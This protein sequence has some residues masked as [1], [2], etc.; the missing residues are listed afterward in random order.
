MT[1]NFEKINI[2]K[3]LD[4][5]IAFLLILGTHSIFSVAVNIDFH[6]LFL[7]MFTIFNRLLLSA[8]Y[9][10]KIKISMV[11]L[12]SFWAIYIFS[13]GFISGGEIKNLFI[14]FILLFILLVIYFFLM[15]DTGQL[16]VFFRAFSNIMLIIAVISIIFWILGSLF[17]IISPNG[18][19][20]F[21]W[22]KDRVAK[23]YNYIYVE[24][25]NDAQIFGKIIYRNIGIFTEAPMF[26]LNLSIALLLDYFILKRRGLRRILLYGLTF[27][28]TISIT[29][30]LLFGMALTLGPILK[31]FSSMLINK[32][33]KPYMLAIP[34]IM[35]AVGIIGV[36]LFNN[37][38][39]SASGSSR[40]EDY[41][42]GFKAWLQNPIFGSGFAN[43]DIRKQFMS[44]I[45]LARAEDGFTNSP[46]T[47]LTEGGIFF[48]SSYLFAFTYPIFVSVRTKN[49][50]L[51]IFILMW[52]FLFVTTTFEHTSA[53]IAFIAF[54]F[55][56]F[57]F[58]SEESVL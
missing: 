33:I 16:K 51:F 18:I 29:G 14:K 10:R 20:N 50:N 54:S 39:S 19:I 35:F 5:A 17:N 52:I 38:L 47:V 37:K 34:I 11:L 48:F 40:M 24:W 2:L 43:T 28:S 7:T 46:T 25:Q 53:M 41:I 22:G 31:T 55:T 49:L 12:I 23:L 27:I 21:Y 8:H 57:C 45:R 4:Y 6:I 26:S 36:F 32:K 13:Y 3:I 9:F 42:V 56:L 58:R 44:A 30:I 15:I 1:I